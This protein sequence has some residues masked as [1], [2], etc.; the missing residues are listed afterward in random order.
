[1]HLSHCDVHVLV[2]VAQEVS[3]AQA[4]TEPCYCLNGGECVSVSNSAENPSQVRCKC[5]QG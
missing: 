2:L 1:M 3:A 4:L 5:Q